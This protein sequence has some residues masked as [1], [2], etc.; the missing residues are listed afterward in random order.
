MATFIGQVKKTTY[1][2]YYQ[3]VQSNPGDFVAR[4]LGKAS[5]PEPSGRFQIGE[6][7]FTLKLVTK[8]K[9]RQLCIERQFENGESLVEMRIRQ[10]MDYLFFRSSTRSMERALRS[11]SAITTGLVRGLRGHADRIVEELWPGF[12]APGAEAGAGT[13]ER[14]GNA[15]LSN[16]RPISERALG[17]LVSLNPGEIDAWIRCPEGGPV[18]LE[19]IDRGKT[20]IEGEVLVLSFKSAGDAIEFR[21]HARGSG[22][23]ERKERARR[24]MERLLS[25]ARGDREDCGYR[26]MAELMGRY[27]VATIEDEAPRLLEQWARGIL[28]DEGNHDVRPLLIGTVR[29]DGSLESTR[30]T[31]RA[32]ARAVDEAMAS[33]RACAAQRFHPQWRVPRQGRSDR[34]RG[35]RCTREPD[36]GDPAEGQAL[37]RGTAARRVRAPGRAGARC[38]G[39]RRAGAA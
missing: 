11:G 38:V 34:I 4:V 32:L 5:G 22:S 23:A 37:C 36:R 20:R 35:A 29:K 33:C 30:A 9:T 17:T 14:R 21:L 19:R 15:A 12:D 3:H 8:G 13:S 25:I 6:E 2:Q 16:R 28:A 7:I 39:R 26:N 18:S 10:L 24:D 31:R 27:M 1:D